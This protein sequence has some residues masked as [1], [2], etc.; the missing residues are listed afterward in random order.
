MLAAPNLELD[1]D[2]GP[3]GPVFLALTGISAAILLSLLAVTI[4]PAFEGRVAPVRALVERTSELPAPGGGTSAAP[5]ETTVV[6]VVATEGEA[7][8]LRRAFEEWDQA[9]RDSGLEAERLIRVVIA[10]RPDE[11]L[12]TFDFSSIRRDVRV[13]DLR[14][15]R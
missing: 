8:R 3:P 13:I 9:I 10:Q 2:A 4:A 14:H 7:D 15:Q 1:R 11:A 12:A 6:Y 5:G